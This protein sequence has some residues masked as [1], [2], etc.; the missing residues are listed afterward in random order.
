MDSRGYDACVPVNDD[1][2]VTEQPL[3]D[4]SAGYVLRSIDQF[5]R[6][7]SRAPRLR[8]GALLSLGLSV[9][10][11][12]L[13]LADAG[14]AIGGGGNAAGAG[15]VL[16]LVGWLACAAGR[17]HLDPDADDLHLPHYSSV[18]TCLGN[19]S[20]APPIECPITATWGSLSASRNASTSSRSSASVWV[21]GQSLRP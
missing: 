16:A 19:L 13:F 18:L 3:L 7:G 2:S 15:L 1:P 12:G 11:F 20:A 6:A 8:L 10:T 14:T 17:W 9:V 4:F 5:P 21:P